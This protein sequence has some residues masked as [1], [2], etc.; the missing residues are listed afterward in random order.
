MTPSNSVAPAPASAPIAARTNLALTGAV[1]FVHALVLGAAPLLA[2]ERPAWFALALVPALLSNL[3][4]GL[5]HEAIHG[6]LHPKP[7]LNTALG[8]A[9]GV[10]FG[11]PFAPLRFAHL[12]HHRY[13]RSPISRDDVYDPARQSAFAAQCRYYAYVGGGLYLGELL[14]NALAWLPVRAQRALIRRTTPAGCAHPPALDALAEQCLLRAAA[15]R[16]F[17]VDALATLLLW[18]AAF[19][20]WGAAAGWLLVL[21]GVRALAISL[22]DNAAHYATPLDQPRYALNL[23]L[24]R[25]LSFWLLHFNLHRTHHDRPALPWHVLPR[26]ADRRPEDPAFGTAVLR[27]LAGAWPA[28]GSAAAMVEPGDAETVSARAA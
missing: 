26:L 18:G 5:V 16:A 19:W 25:A 17:R 27:Q 10:A 23:R 22:L 7:A 21:L 9:L 4:W 11:A 13:N 24:P 12:R 1:L 15:Q 2:R 28:P 20:W 3:H 14:L 8:R 6:L